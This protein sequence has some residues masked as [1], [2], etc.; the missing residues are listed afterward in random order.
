[1]T[2]YRLK[3]LSNGLP[4]KPPRMRTRAAFVDEGIAR[5]RIGLST[6]LSAVQRVL[7]IQFSGT[8]SFEGA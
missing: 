8:V 1:M 7:T 5:L 2:G 6:R 4:T 3:K